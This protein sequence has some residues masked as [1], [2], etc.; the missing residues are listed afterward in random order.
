MGNNNKANKSFAEEGLEDLTQD[1]EELLAAVPESS[2]MGE[3][4]TELKQVGGLEAVSL[5]YR[6]TPPKT[7]PKSPTQVIS[8]GFELKGVYERSFISGKMK[9]P[10]FLIR[11]NEGKLVGIGGAGS[12]EKSLLKVAEG[13]KVHIIYDGTEIIKGGDWAGNIAHAFRVFAAKLKP[14]SDN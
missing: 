3:D 1:G 14:G 10:T 12:L 11:N 13:S 2:G 9:K 6:L 7:P 8:K 5:F 4:E